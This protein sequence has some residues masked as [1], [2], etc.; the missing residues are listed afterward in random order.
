MISPHGDPVQYKYGETTKQ[1]PECDGVIF[2]SNS[3]MEFL[4]RVSD[5]P[6]SFVGI[7]SIFLITLLNDVHGHY[8]SQSKG[9]VQYG[10]TGLR[11]WWLNVFSSGN[12]GMAVQSQFDNQRKAMN[13]LVGLQFKMVYDKGKENLVTNYYVHNMWPIVTIQSPYEV[14]FSVQQDK[15]IRLHQLGVD[16]SAAF[17]TIL[18]STFYDSIVWEYFGRAVSSMLK[19]QLVRDQQF[20]ESDEECIGFNNDMRQ[21]AIHFLCVLHYLISATMTSV[22]CCLRVLEQRNSYLQKFAVNLIS[23]SH[24]LFVVVG[25]HSLTSRYSQQYCVLIVP[26][27]IQ[28]MW[29]SKNVMCAKM[30]KSSCYEVVLLGTITRVQ[31]LLQDLFNGKELCKHII[32]DEMEFREVES[33]MICVCLHEEDHVILWE[34]PRLENWFCRTK[35][36]LKLLINGQKC[37]SSLCGQI[38][39]QRRLVSLILPCLGTSKFWRGGIC[40]G[41]Y[42]DAGVCGVH[43]VDLYVTAFACGP[44]RLV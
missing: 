38:F 2:F 3:S 34:T 4:H 27:L 6:T 25:F 29:D 17:S 40:H 8:D 41:R 10:I 21:F 39:M 20:M 44:W 33:N 43:S 13:K 22:K 42:L 5:V 9:C 24:L 30:D 15:V 12:S 7:G 35:I 19:E 26:E 32:F 28:Q 36:F 31:Q 1:M 23:F 16:R 18:I 37:Q 11:Q 14:V